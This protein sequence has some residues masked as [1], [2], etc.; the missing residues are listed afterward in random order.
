V[1]TNLRAAGASSPLIDGT[2]RRVALVCGRFN[3]RIVEQLERGARRALVDAGVADDAITTIWVPGA[4]EVPQLT[5]AATASGRFDAVVALGAVVRGDTYHFEVV[6]D[7]SAAGLM[8]LS[9][10]ADVVITN[11]ILTVDDEAQAIARSGDDDGN[12]GAQAALAALETL[13][14]IDSLR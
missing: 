3:D 12:K 1:S 11:G 14:A 4:L 5:K 13:A 2:G 10:D 7:A 9:L 6:S 8:Q